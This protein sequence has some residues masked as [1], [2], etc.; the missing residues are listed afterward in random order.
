[1]E[2]P[3]R[4]RFNRRYDILHDIV[5]DRQETSPDGKELR[6]FLRPENPRLVRRRGRLRRAK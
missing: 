6:V 4:H 3:H 2:W 5:V 1:M